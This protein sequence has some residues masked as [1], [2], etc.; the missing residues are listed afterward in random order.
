MSGGFDHEVELP[1]P[2][3]GLWAQLDD[4]A[5]G[6]IDAET[7]GEDG[8]AAYRRRIGV[9]KEL[10]PRQKERRRADNRRFAAQYPRWTKGTNLREFLAGLTDEQRRA[11]DRMVEMNLPLAYAQAAK[12]H[13]HRRHVGM[14]SDL[15][16][17][18]QEANLGLC[19][20]AA[21]FDPERGGQFSTFAVPV[22]DRR[23]DAR[24]GIRLRS[25]RDRER[26]EV[27]A[28][29]M[30][31]QPADGPRS[32]AA[33]EPLIS[34]EGEPLEP[35]IR[36]RVVPWADSELDQLDDEQSRALRG[37]E[38]LREIGAGGLTDE[39]GRRPST[40]NVDSEADLALLWEAARRNGVQR[41][42]LRC[43]YCSAEFRSRSEEASFEWFRTHDCKPQVAP[44]R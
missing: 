30:R 21:R 38:F 33:I 12:M 32:V 8:L 36:E 9:G 17:C 40:A 7:F 23:L 1:L 22:I 39:K 6:G 41:P 34:V 18:I 42:K 29:S 35:S 13:R 28:D 10:T 25:A 5:T 19:E 27:F 14:P 43:D 2:T 26:V 11:F 24:V 15:G 4:G 20:A 37:T 3:P 16:I 44:T 31:T